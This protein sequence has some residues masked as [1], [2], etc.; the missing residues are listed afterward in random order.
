M[1]EQKEEHQAPSWQDVARLR[2]EN[3]RLLG[4]IEEQDIHIKALEGFVI[5]FVGEEAWA[6]ASSSA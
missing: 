6:A 4:I 5:Q 3:E 2:L 1:N